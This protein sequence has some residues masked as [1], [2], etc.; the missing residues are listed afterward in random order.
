M[1]RLGFS[2]LTLAVLLSTQACKEDPCETKD[3]G[4]FGNCVAVDDEASCNCEDG[5]ELDD[6]G[7]CSIYSITH[8]QGDF[9]TT[10]IC[11]DHLRNDT[12]Y[13]KSYDLTI[14]LA[15]FTEINLES[16][17][18]FFCHTGP[19]TAKA[20]VTGNDFQLQAGTYCEDIVNQT[21]YDISGNGQISQEGISFSYQLSFSQFGTVTTDETCAVTLT[22]K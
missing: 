15:S 9:T 12:T 6:D 19:L 16:L 13:Q 3:C 7:L 5:F 4:P 2:I 1:K 22:T 11:T 20:T 18:G 10:E 17:G 14:S 21:Q 8:F